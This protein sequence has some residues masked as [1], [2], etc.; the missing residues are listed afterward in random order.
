MITLYYAPDNASLVVKILL[1]ELSLPYKA[2]LVDRGIR[3]QSSK[4]YRELNPKGLIPV[5]II[6]GEP[7]FETAAILLS[8][9]DR[10]GEMVPHADDAARPQFLKWLFFLSNTLHPDLRMLFYAE[11]YIS[12]EKPVVENFRQ[13]TRDRLIDSFEILDAHYQQLDTTYLLGDAPSLVD[14]YCAVC[15]R[16]SAL[17]PAD[18]GHRLLV[19]DFPALE[20]M[21][22]EL[23][24]RRP[25]IRACNSEGINGLFF[26]RPEYAK[27]TE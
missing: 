16:W 25:V 15:M 5:C 1:E 26:T 2:V 9:A 4:A 3:E 10:Q 24:R 20:A 18:W 23:E 8:L 22:T 6:D 21:F 27:V 17:Y 19:S 14:M 11:K 7:V 12:A 13:T